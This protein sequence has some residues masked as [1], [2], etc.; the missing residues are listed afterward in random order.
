MPFGILDPLLTSVLA[1]F[2]ATEKDLRNRFLYKRN[3][4]YIKTYVAN[5][6]LRDLSLIQTMS[7]TLHCK[8]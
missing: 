8:I 2:A 7:Y 5:T 6:L 3:V 4:L 1:G